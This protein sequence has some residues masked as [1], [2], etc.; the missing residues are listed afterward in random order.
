M[1]LD[2]YLQRKYYIGG[3][4]EPNDVKGSLDISKRGKKINID[5]NK[6][7][8][9]ITRA[10]Y[11]RKAN[12]IHGWFVDNVQDGVDNC[13]EYYVSGERLAELYDTCKRVLEE[14]SVE[15]AKLHLPA[16]QGFFFGSDGSDDDYDEYYWQ[17]L[18]YTIKAID[19]LRVDDPD[20]CEDYS[21]QSSW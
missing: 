9:V 3:C 20:L 10:A 14:H 18:E 11:W 12:Q 2:M 5:L 21:Y 19:E 8:Y 15:A 16:T 4:Y 7:S 13:A 6:V 1:G 17:D